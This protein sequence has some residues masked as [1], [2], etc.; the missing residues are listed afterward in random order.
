MT[1]KKMMMMMNY[2]YYQINH[3]LTLVNT[4]TVSRVFNILNGFNLIS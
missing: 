1:M 4:V 3:L 2:T